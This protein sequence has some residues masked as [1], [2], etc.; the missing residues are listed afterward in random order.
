MIQRR[1]ARKFDV[2]L[3]PKRVLMGVLS[4]S[5]ATLDSIHLTQRGHDLLARQVRAI[6]GRSS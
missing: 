6:L 5:G 1:P 3:I 2:T 4:A